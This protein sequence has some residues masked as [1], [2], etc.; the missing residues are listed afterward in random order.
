MQ[1]NRFVPTPIAFFCAL[2]AFAALVPAAP[3]DE[4]EG[5]IEHRVPHPNPSAAYKWLEILLE[6]SG[7]DVEKVGARPTIISRQM[8]IPLTAMY[9]AWAAYDDKAVGTIFCGEFR[10]PGT[11]RTKA[12]KATAI[13]HAMYRTLLNIFPEDAAWLERKMR[14]MG[15]DPDDQSTDRSTPQGIGNVV[16]Q[17]ILEYRRNDGANQ[18]G[19]EVGSCGK[20]YSDYTFYVPRNTNERVYDPDC[21]QRIPFDDGKGGTFYPCFLT[22]HWYRVKPFALDR[23]DQFRAPPFPKVDSEQ[24]KKEVAEVVYMNGH[25]SLE[26]KAV[27]EFMRDGPRSTGQSGHWLQFA[28]DVSRRDRYDLDQDVKLFFTIGNTAF[29]AFIACWESKRYYDSSRPWTLIRHLYKDQE[30]IGYLGP[31][32]GFGKIPAG[33][34]IPY[35]PSTFPTPPFPGYPSGH[36]TV[37]GACSK[38]LELFTDSDEFGCYA[39][40][41][42][43]QWT[44]A[45]CEPKKMQTCNGKAPPE[46]PDSAKIIL[47]MPAFTATAEMAGISRV[48][49]GYHIQ[50]DNQEGLAM[51]RKVATY[52]WPIYQSYF[53]GTKSHGS[54]PMQSAMR[55]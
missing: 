7:R 25:L 21:W 27:V 44:E 37:S 11:E 3:P 10:R 12:N 22:P 50:A 42:A 40:H 46:V 14:E 17:A 29:D 48:M 43:G 39:H 9:D 24:L 8:A 36:S 51:G 23:S 53:N 32:K 2:F 20:P 30:I 5:W 45:G 38:M 34:W 49:G 41:V 54:K 19:D 18:Y 33:K 52:T 15:H 6:V 13:A 16:A 28:Q 55:N 1:S 47:L 31:C 35:S 4:P 26:D